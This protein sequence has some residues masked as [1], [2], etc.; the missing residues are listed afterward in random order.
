MNTI[1]YGLEALSFALHHDVEIEIRQGGRYR[2]ATLAEAVAL[3]RAQEL[4]T[5]PDSEAVR[6]DLEDGEG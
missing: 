1:L 5:T 3:H 4:S 6:V 2:R